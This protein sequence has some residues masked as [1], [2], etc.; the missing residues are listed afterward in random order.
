M[1]MSQLKIFKERLL[2][3]KPLRKAVLLLLLHQ[4]RKKVV[5]KNLLRNQL[6]SREEK[7]SAKAIEKRKADEMKDPLNPLKETSKRAK[8]EETINY[9]FENLLDVQDLVN[10]AKEHSLLDHWPTDSVN[11][12]IAPLL[13]IRY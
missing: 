3:K 12:I 13:T 5:R 2:R 9:D 8:E 10:Y 4:Q 7:S 1:R 6:Q 11:R